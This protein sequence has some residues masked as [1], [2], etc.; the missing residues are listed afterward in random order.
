MHGLDPNPCQAVF[1]TPSSCVRNPI[2]EAEIPERLFNLKI[3]IFRPP[4]GLE[5]LATVLEQYGAAA[6]EGTVERISKLAE[7]IVAIIARNRKRVNS[8]GYYRRRIELKAWLS[9]LSDYCLLIT[10][11]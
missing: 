5:R 11:Y 3:S 9:A 6:E 8:S 1:R 7:E 2:K 4:L 10:D